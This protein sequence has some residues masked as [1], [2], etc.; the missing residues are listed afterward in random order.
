MLTVFLIGKGT[1]ILARSLLFVFISYEEKELASSRTKNWFCHFTIK[2]FFLSFI[3]QKIKM[4]NV[5]QNQKPLFECAL[6]HNR[7]EKK[8]KSWRLRSQ[9]Q[10]LKGFPIFE[11]G[12]LWGGGLIK[13]EIYTWQSPKEGSDSKEHPL[14]NAWRFNSPEHTCHVWE[15]HQMFKN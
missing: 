11:M 8:L 5:C 15:W 1:C 7:K 12:P 2:H 13:N 10:L 9:V 4:Q 6:L 14:T 3:R